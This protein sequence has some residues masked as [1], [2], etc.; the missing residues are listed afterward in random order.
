MSPCTAVVEKNSKI[1]TALCGAFCHHSLNVSDISKHFNL[2]KLNIMKAMFIFDF[3]L[4]NIKPFFNL[5]TI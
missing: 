1:P 5:L 4:S 2:K 3:F